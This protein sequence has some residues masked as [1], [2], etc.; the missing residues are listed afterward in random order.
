MQL[1]SFSAAALR[2]L[3]TNALAHSVG[4]ISTYSPPIRIFYKKKASVNIS[5]QFGGQ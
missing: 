2:S 5:V 1:P 3:C 4:E